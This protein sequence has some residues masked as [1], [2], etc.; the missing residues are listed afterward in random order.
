VTHE[1]VAAEAV[2]AA[3]E[4]LYQDRRLLMELSARAYTK[5]HEET[6]KWP[7]IGEQWSD[8]FEEELA[9]QVV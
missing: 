6:W 7:R 1:V 9:L 8:L 5:T 3:L 4:R 2:A